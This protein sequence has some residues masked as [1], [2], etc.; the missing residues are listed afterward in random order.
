ML[1]SVADS[2]PHLG[3]RVKTKMRLQAYLDEKKLSYRALGRQRKPP[4]SH[5]TVR[6]WALGLRFPQ[7]P[8]DIAWLTNVTEGQV[9]ANDIAEH[10]LEIRQHAAQVNLSPVEYVAQ[11]ERAA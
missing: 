11:M 1:W 5:S 7:D 10:V 2:P 4:V 8:A 9:T 6:Q 3:F